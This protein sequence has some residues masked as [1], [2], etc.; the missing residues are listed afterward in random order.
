MP[1]PSKSPSSTPSMKSFSDEKTVRA[2][3]EANA[4]KWEQTHGGKSQTDVFRGVMPT[5]PGGGVPGDFTE[6]FSELGFKDV[7]TSDPPPAL[8]MQGPVFNCNFMY[9]DTRGAVKIP[10]FGNDKYILQHPLG[11]PGRDLGDDSKS[12][13][14]H[15]MVV[16]VGKTGPVT[17][18]EMLP[19]DKTEVDDLEERI[20]FLETAVQGIKKNIPV[21]DC[22]EAVK[23]KASEMNVSHD[24]GIREFLARQISGLPE[25]VRTG[26]PGYTLMNASNQDI[27]ASGC[28]TILA[29][30]NDVFDDESL[31]LVPCVQDGDNC[32]QLLTHIHAFMV[33]SIPEGLKATYTDC[34]TILKVKKDLLPDEGCELQRAASSLGRT[35]SVAGGGLARTTSVAASSLGRTTSVALD[36][37]PPLA[38]Q[39]TYAVSIP[40]VS[41]DG[42]AP[43]CTDPAPTQEPTQE[44]TDDFSLR[45]AMSVAAPVNDAA[46]VAVRT[47]SA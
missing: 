14:S 18:N 3:L 24:T 34:R 40:T 19:S 15:M 5:A 46:P 26:R 9:R 36:E 6:T 38:R 11:E 4:L 35:T 17:F 16:S 47:S 28:A 32:S 41:E 29:A 45:R 1:T 44:P 20:Q 25:S 43:A 30:I 31:E 2:S 37:G 22:G 7:F 27:A 23:A 39:E 21:S 12:K 8:K 13:I 42:A 10:V 33:A